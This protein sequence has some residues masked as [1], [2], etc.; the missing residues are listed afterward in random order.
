MGY[1]TGASSYGY[2]QQPNIS[3]FTGG[4]QQYNYSGP[5]TNMNWMNPSAF[6]NTQFTQPTSVMGLSPQGGGVM[7]QIGSNIAANPMGVASAGMGAASY[8]A[9]MVNQA[10]SY[11]N[12]EA[13]DATYKD[14]SGDI[15]LATSGINRQIKQANP[16]SA[17]K[18]AIL[19]GTMTGAGLGTAIFPGIGT[20]IGAAAGFIGGLIGKKRI[21]RRAAEAQGRMYAAKNE[22]INTYNRGITAE[23][24]RDVGE[25]ITMARRRNQMKNVF[26]VPQYGAPIWNV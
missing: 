26:G 23:S 14:Q 12:M 15:Q 10:Q 22:D 5:S 3:Q 16:N 18:G 21:K 24:M 9:D 11:K 13:V 7:G 8:V 25:D 19:G 4:M 20:A 17:G 2:M 1:L 6:A